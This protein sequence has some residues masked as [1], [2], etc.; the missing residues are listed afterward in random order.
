MCYVN[1]LHH[2]IG[3]KW[4]RVTSLLATASSHVFIGLST[5]LSELCLKETRECFR[6]QFVHSFKGFTRDDMAI[7]TDI[8]ETSTGS[9]Y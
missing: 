1:H 9:T 8:T 6:E 3:K 4:R 7:L 5:N 2:L